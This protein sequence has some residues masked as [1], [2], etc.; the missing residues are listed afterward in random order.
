MSSYESTNSRFLVLPS[1]TIML[2][3]LL[4]SCGPGPKSSPQALNES[5]E[6]AL[7][8]SEKIANRFGSGSVRE[9][10][11]LARLSN[12]FADMTAASVAAETSAVYAENAYLNDNIVFLEGADAI[13]KYFSAGAAKV[14][15]LNVEFLNVGRSG[16][17]YYIRWRMSILS[18]R[19]N[20]GQ[21][22]VSYGVSHF[23]F[24]DDGRVLLHKDFWDAGTSVYEYLPFVG[25]IVRSLRGRLA[26]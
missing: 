15:R 7:V 18:D 26:H 14:D 12:Y 5:Y 10:E 4:A 16:I 25:G 17:D 20:D 1:I 24:A 11:M 9:R 23:R 21:A 2:G 19:L 8:R 22:M 3:V 6:L 13:E